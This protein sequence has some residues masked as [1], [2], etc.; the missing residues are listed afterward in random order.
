M[1]RDWVRLVLVSREGLL[2]PHRMGLYRLTS[3]PTTLPA[4]APP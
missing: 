4:A 3:N 1:G 2:N